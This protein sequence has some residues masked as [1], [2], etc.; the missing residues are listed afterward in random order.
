MFFVAVSLFFAAHRHRIPLPLQVLCIVSS[1]GVQEREI[2]HVSLCT[3][4]AA[5]VSFSS[6]FISSL[7]HVPDP[8]TRRPHVRIDARQG[9]AL[10][11]SGS[12]QHWVMTSSRQGQGPADIQDR[13]GQPIISVKKDR[14]TTW[15]LETLSRILSMMLSWLTLSV[16]LAFG[17][18]RI[19]VHY[20]IFL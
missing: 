3:P 1:Y 12:G 18:N 15:P 2:K 17:S 14:L 9:Q 11:R 19:L 10:H 20:C 8:S 13:K 5:T 16:I 6:F 7:C 4:Y